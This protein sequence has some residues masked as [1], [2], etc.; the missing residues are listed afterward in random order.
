MM[1]KF[2]LVRHGQPTY[3]EVI[4]EGF[5]GHGIAFAPLTTKG[6]NEVKASAENS[7]F[8]SSDILISSPYTRAMQTASII[9]RRYNLDVNVEL[10]LHE[11]IVDY[12][13]SY[14][15]T[16]QFLKNIRRAKDEYKKSLDNPLFEFSVEFESLPHVRQRAISVLQKYLSYNKVIVVSHGLLINTL[17]NGIKLDTGSFVMVSSEDIIK[18]KKMIR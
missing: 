11:W 14:N 18:E 16:E 13:N 9:G 7:I 10:L 3:D 15:T 6:I 2:I 4:K 8:E 12:S 5:K 17:L 1:T